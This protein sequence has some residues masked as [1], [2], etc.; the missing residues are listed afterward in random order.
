LIILDVGN[1]IVGGSPTDPREVSRV[2][3][4]GGQT[5]NAWYWPERGLVFVGEEDFTTPGMMHVVDVADLLAPVEVASF[6]IPAD[7]PH[8]FWLDEGRE[9]LHMAWYT[10]GIVSLDVAGELLGD[11]ERQ[12]RILARQRYSGFGDCPG[13]AT[14]TCAWAPQLHEGLLYLADM[15]TGLWVLTPDF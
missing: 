12:G 1:G 2:R 4:R 14:G 8:N 9:I 6:R 3:T 10:E 15:N 5:H 7:T 11:L 13:S